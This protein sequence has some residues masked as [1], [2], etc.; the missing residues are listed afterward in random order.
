V[1]IDQ[2][3]P[4]QIVRFR[5]MPE[6][7]SNLYR[8]TVAISGGRSWSVLVRA[9]DEES[10]VGA[11]RARGHHVTGVKAAEMPKRVV[12]P[13]R[14]SCLNC[15]YLLKNLPVGDAGEVL[16]PECGVINTS[17]A[18]ADSMWAEYKAVRAEF[19]RARQQRPIT[20][21]PLTI[22]GFA[23]AFTIAILVIVPLLRWLGWIA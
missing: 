3:I 2:S 13:P 16:C 6:I 19:K 20:T 15:G 10:A 18:E 8:V 11:V 21:R 12:A 1:W 22:I 9:V 5:V 4:E 14:I 7:V 23:A 17:G